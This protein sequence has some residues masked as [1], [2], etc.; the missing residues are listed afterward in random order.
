QWK[1]RIGAVEGVFEECAHA[2]HDFQIAHDAATNAFANG[3]GFLDQL[4]HYLEKLRLQLR[5][6]DRQKKVLV[7]AFAH[8]IADAFVH[9]DTARGDETWH[10]GHDAVVTRRN[11][12]S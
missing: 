6:V 2:R 9:R 8:Q 4:L 7:A 5:V 3:I 12:A 10:T 1:F 11:H